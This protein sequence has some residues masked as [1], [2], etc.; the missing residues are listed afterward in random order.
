VLLDGTVLEAEAGDV[1][2]WLRNVVRLEER[3]RIIN[4][5]LTFVDEQSGVEGVSVQADGRYKSSGDVDKKDGVEASR[6]SNN[7]TLSVG[8]R[9]RR[10]CRKE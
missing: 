1:I 3:I 6:P 9:S 7:K 8:C 10:P 2:R 4:G 5:H